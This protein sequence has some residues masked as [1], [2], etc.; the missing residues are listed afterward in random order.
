MGFYDRIAL[1][2]MICWLAFSDRAAARRSIDDLL[3]RP[4]ERV[5]VGHGAPIDSGGHE[6]IAA[7]YTFLP[8]AA[9]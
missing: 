1:S 8:A 3:T 5:I 2:R 6:A 7:A 4:F 9:R